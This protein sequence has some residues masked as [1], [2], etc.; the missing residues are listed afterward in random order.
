METSVEE[1]KGDIYLKQDKKELARTA[2][3]AALSANALSTSPVLQM[4]R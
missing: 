4:K 2:Y 3:Q 1:I